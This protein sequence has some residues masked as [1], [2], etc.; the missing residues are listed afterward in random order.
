MLDSPMPSPSARSTN[1]GG[2]EDQEVRGWEIPGPPSSTG[3]GASLG[4]EEAKMRAGCALVPA[5]SAEKKDFGRGHV[6]LFFDVTKCCLRG[7]RRGVSS[8]QRRLPPK[9]SLLSQ[10]RPLRWW[11]PCSGFQPP[12]C[13]AAPEPP[14]SCP[15]PRDPILVRSSAPAASP[16]LACPLSILTLTPCVIW[17]G[18]LICKLGS[19]WEPHAGGSA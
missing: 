13:L 11:R 5:F 12:P 9:G 4:G 2:C 1:K 8:G 18:C 16:A 14:T 7:C 6:S 10:S 19:S 17:G 3:P 15:A